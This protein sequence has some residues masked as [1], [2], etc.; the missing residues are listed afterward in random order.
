MRYTQK[1][2]PSTE[3]PPETVCCVGTMPAAFAAKAAV[4]SAHNTQTQE[5]APKPP[6]KRT[7]IA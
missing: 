7:A 6:P 4:S 1:G 3:Q 5:N 2:T